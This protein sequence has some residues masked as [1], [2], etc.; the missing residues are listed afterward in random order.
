MKFKSILIP[1]ITILLAV[2]VPLGAIAADWDVETTPACSNSIAMETVTDAPDV[3]HIVYNSS[4]LK[5]AYRT[6]ASS[7]TAETVA[8][9]NGDGASFVLD[10]SGVP[11]VAYSSTN[12]VEIKYTERTSGFNGGSWDTQTVQ[13]YEE[14][15]RDVDLP[16]FYTADPNA[17]THQITS[18]DD[19]SLVL[20]NTGSARVSYA[21]NWW[22][23]STNYPFAA[24]C[25]A[26]S[27]M[28]LRYRYDDGSPPWTQVLPAAEFDVLGGVDNSLALD[29]S[30]NYNLIHYNAE[31]SGDRWTRFLSTVAGPF[32]DEGAADTGGFS[33]IMDGSN[34]LHISYIFWDKNGTGTHFLRYAKYDSSLSSWSTTDIDAANDLTAPGPTSLSL[35]SDGNPHIAYYDSGDQELRY[36]SYNGAS[37]NIEASPVTTGQSITELSMALDDLDYPHISFCGTSSDGYAHFLDSDSDAHPDHADNCPVDSNHDQ[38][39]SDG[40]LP[41]MVAYWK[42]DVEEGLVGYDTVD[43]DE[44]NDGVINHADRSTGRVNGGLQFQGDGSV[45][46]ELAVKSNESLNITGDVTVEAWVYQDSALPPGTIDTIVIKS[47]WGWGIQDG[48]GLYYRN[49]KVH[50]F[51]NHFSDHIASAPFSSGEWHHVAGTYDGSTIRIFV[52]GVE[53]TSSSYSGTIVH[54]NYPFT[55]SGT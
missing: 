28:S 40:A 8:D 21:V 48:Y 38:A 24:P 36:A 6:G 30:N 37:W 2:T 11:H 23:D 26:E 39:E 51:I 53:G 43:N 52:D 45:R 55:L 19:I 1:I 15:K 4:G 54:R 42:L 20:D 50:F 9:G 27:T 17:V 44:N 25:S 10:S 41:G 3:P 47:S 7:W 18:Y 35:D 34:D 46:S 12:S 16:P 33:S 22:C 5:H 32:P 13:Q 14:H 31:P 29:S 49:G